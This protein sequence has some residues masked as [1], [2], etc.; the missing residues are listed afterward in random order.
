MKKLLISTFFITASL[1]AFSQKA[2]FSENE[3]KIKID[4]I[5]QHCNQ[6]KAQS[7]TLKL[8]LSNPNNP[9][10]L[11]NLYYLKRNIGKEQLKSTLNSLSE[12]NKSDIYAKSLDIYINTKQVIE[13]DRYF[14]FSAKSSKNEDFLLS[15][16]IKE[17]D[18]LLIFGGLS[19]MG[20]SSRQELREL[21]SKL[22]LSKVEVVSF[23]DVENEEEQKEQIKKYDVNWVTI[24]DYQGVLSNPWLAY[25][26]KGLPTTVYINTK[27]EIL[28][29]RP[30]L[31]N[32]AIKLLKNHVKV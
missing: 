3:C 10:S 13:G 4:S 12:V 6:K 2:E 5:Y 18:V 31:V 1:Y 29:T 15:N 14:D 23:L 20:E 26:G 32:K 9:T 27:G 21:Y 24:S 30:G 17:K 11:K 7:E 19:C 16:V 25:V 28:V 22:D 8:C